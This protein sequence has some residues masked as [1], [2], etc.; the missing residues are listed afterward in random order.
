MKKILLFFILVNFF[1]LS[2]FSFTMLLMSRKTFVQTD[3]YPLLVSDISRCIISKSQK[4]V[5]PAEHR[6]KIDKKLCRTY[7][8]YNPL[9]SNSS[10]NCAE[11][12]YCIKRDCKNIVPGGRFFCPEHS[13]I[14]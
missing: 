13:L 11:H 9:L 8:C 5:V 14:I 12:N 2:V 3:M 10:I 4:K 7:G 6:A 1:G